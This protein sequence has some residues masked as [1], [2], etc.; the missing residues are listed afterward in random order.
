MIAQIFIPTA[1]FAIPTGTLD[2]EAKADIQTQS[3]TAEMK[4]REYSKWF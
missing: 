4:I 1:E 2:N 3:L